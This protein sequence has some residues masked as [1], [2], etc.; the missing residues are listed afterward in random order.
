MILGGEDM[1]K[2]MLL[3]GKICSG[4]SYYAN[5]L[6]EKHKAVLLS[7]DELLMELSLAELGDKHDETVEKVKEYLYKKSLE[8]AGAGAD[9]IL[10][11]GF[12]SREERRKVSEYY[13]EHQTSYE[14]HYIDISEEA[15]RKNIR[16]RNRKV[17]EGTDPSFYVDDGLLNK[18]SSL[19][20]VPENDE[21][22]IWFENTERNKQKAETNT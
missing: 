15:W 18:L 19:F 8:I 9:V 5:S 12:W 2:V 7:C 21:I 13:K 16:E 20:E 17:L 11:F 22:D 1:A 4:K 10:D 6:K 14:W 3:C